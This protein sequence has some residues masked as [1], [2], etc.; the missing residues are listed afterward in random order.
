MFT[1]G[2]RL[3]LRLCHLFIGTVSFVGKKLGR[4]GALKFLSGV[5]QLFFTGFDVVYGVGLMHRD[6]TLLVNTATP[7]DAASCQVTVEDEEE[8]V[9]LVSKSMLSA[10]PSKL[11][12]KLGSHLGDDTDSKE[13]FASIQQLCKVFTPKLAHSAYVTMCLVLGQLNL[14][15][16]LYNTELVEQITYSHDE[17]IQALTEFPQPMHFA[18]SCYS[19]DQ[20]GYTSCDSGDECDLPNNLGPFI[21]INKG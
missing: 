17:A 2:W 21:N 16:E 13:N 20:S 5:L 7:N 6:N 19:S 18:P 10:T 11:A 14:R 12:Q 8:S 3:R 9:P 1:T 15:R 4:E